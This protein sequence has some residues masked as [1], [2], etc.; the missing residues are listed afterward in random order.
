MK[1]EMLQDLSNDMLD[2]P[3]ANIVI[4]HNGK[5]YATENYFHAY[6]ENGSTIIL[7]KTG[8]ESNMVKG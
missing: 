6:A 4:E 1:K 5:R 2:M 8:K 3:E 7:I